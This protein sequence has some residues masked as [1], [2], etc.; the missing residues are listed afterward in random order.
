[1]HMSV[2]IIKP[3]NAG[4]ANRGVSRNPILLANQEPPANARARSLSPHNYIN[5]SL[6]RSRR[7]EVLVNAAKH[8]N[9]HSSRMEGNRSKLQRF[10]P[11]QP[12][13]SLSPSKPQSLKARSLRPRALSPE[14]AMED[15]ESPSLNQAASQD[16][17]QAETVPSDQSA[18]SDVLEACEQKL[19]EHVR[20]VFDA[21]GLRHCH[22]LPCVPKP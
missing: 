9:Q 4:D 16:Q 3:R 8:R 5:N 18:A 14:Q 12:R 10:Q 19:I 17:N 11:V 2:D 6:S 21:G 15:L 7:L 20:A 22:A 1:M 13:Q